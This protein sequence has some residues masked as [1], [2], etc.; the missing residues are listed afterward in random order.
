MTDSFFAWHSGLMAERV[1]EFMTDAS[2]APFFQREIARFGQP[3]LDLACGA[4]RLL[5]P[6]L[7]AGVDVDGCDASADMLRRCRVKA[8]REGYEPRLHQQPMHAFD[9]PRRYRTI[10]I[11]NAFGLAGSRDQDLATLRRCQAHLEDGGALLLNIEAEYTSP[12]EWEMWEPAKRRT[13]PEPWP[14]EGRRRVAADG[15]EHVSRLRLVELNPLDQSYVRQL[16]LEKWVSGQLVASEELTLRGNLYLKNELV[17]MLQAAGLRDI[18]VRG[19][20]TDEPATP[21]S[22]QLVLTAIR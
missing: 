13:L 18:T 3:A 9:L 2:E 15:S 8:A 1:A 20:Y 11:C 6:L 5:L 7:R 16:G 14:E 10:Y 21:D 19:D 22:K 17:L 12:E 4:G